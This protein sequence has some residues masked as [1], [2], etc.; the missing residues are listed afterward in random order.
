MTACTLVYPAVINTFSFCQLL[1]V[2]CM[3]TVC[4][5]EHLRALINAMCAGFALFV[6]DPQ[7]F[8]LSAFSPTIDIF[9]LLGEILHMFYMCAQ[10]PSALSMSDVSTQSAHT[11]IHTSTP[12]REILLWP[13]DFS[14]FF[15]RLP[16]H[17]YLYVDVTLY[18][19]E[20]IPETQTVHNTCTGYHIVNV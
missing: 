8:F 12:W 13:V 16:T 5:C 3:Q 17:A 7:I 4:T 20:Y 11:H 19:N 15:W 14:T 9:I 18:I 6:L 2:V 1:I 10:L